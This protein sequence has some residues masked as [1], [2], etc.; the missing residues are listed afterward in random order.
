MVIGYE[1]EMKK[2]YTKM[3]WKR[4]NQK[5]VMTSDFYFM[6]EYIA[7]QTGWIGKTISDIE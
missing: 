5:I 1:N 3:L 6:L 7:E 4:Q 2:L